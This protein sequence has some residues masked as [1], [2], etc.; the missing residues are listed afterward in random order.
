[1]PF[2][3]KRHLLI[4]LF[5]CMGLH[6]LLAQNYTISGSVTDSASGET[7][8]GATIMDLRSGKGTRTNEQGRFSLTLRSDTLDLRISYV[9]YKS[10]SERIVLRSNEKRNYRLQSSVQLQTVVVRGN[11]IAMIFQPVPN[12]R[13]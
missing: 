13:R 5:L 12:H 11:R 8:I 1:M 7:L 9:G 4:L 3:R 10:Q 6:P 2:L